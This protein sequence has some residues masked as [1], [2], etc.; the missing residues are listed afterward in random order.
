MALE[1]LS[2]HAKVD[3]HLDPLVHGQY[4]ITELLIHLKL[5]F[6]ALQF[7]LLLTHVSGASFFCLEVCNSLLQLLDLLSS[8]IFEI[9][10]LSECNRVQLVGTVVLEKHNDLLA[11]LRYS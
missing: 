4:L 9:V 10:I 8:I 5:R 3:R 1:S 7:P 2:A 11:S 6:N